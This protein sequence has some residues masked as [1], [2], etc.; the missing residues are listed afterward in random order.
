[1]LCVLGLSPLAV[2][3][4]A[5]RPDYLPITFHLHVTGRMPARMTFWVAYGPL[6]GRFGV[7]QLRRT[8]AGN[9]RATKRLP[10]HGRGTFTYLAS[11][12]TTTTP[13]GPAPGGP[14]IIIRSFRLVTAPEVARIK[15][16]WRAPQG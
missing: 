13:A 9:F 15:I 10:A 16:Y 12:G 1:M 4:I 7:L 8:S 5:A 14:T 6:A 11:F 2:G 3:A